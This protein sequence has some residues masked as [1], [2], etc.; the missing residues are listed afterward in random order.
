MNNK[1]L[2]VIDFLLE[3]NRRFAGSLSVHPNQ[4]VGRRKE[5]AAGQKPI[6]AILGC[7]DSRV[8]PE[9]IF[10]CGIGDLFVVRTAGTVIDDSVIASLEYAVEHL[11]IPLVMALG[12]TSC[13]AVTAALKSKDNYGAGMLEDCLGKIRRICAETAGKEPQNIDE[14][15]K[16]YTLRIAETLRSTEPVLKPACERK[17]CAVVA[18]CYSLTEGKVELLDDVTP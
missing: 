8:P 13:G 16:K 6:A 17:A 5:C 14:T 4:D 12:H 11:H 15:I 2:E 9:V 1:A 7:A 10:D 18:A 3:G